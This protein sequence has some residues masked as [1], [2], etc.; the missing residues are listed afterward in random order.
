MADFRLRKRLEIELAIERCFREK[1]GPEGVSE[2]HT[3][4]I[5]RADFDQLLREI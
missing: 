3:I 4:I 2:G 1:V 5:R